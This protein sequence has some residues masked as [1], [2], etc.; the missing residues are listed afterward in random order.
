MQ[1][2]QNIPAPPVSGRLRDR[3]REV[4]MRVIMQEE[5]FI[6][7]LMPEAE[8]DRT[9]YPEAEFRRHF[10][11]VF[12]GEAEKN[13][14]PGYTPERLR[15][16]AHTYWATI[17]GGL[18]C[19]VDVVDETGEVVFTV[20]ALSDTSVLNTA[21]NPNTP[22]LKNLQEDVLQDIQG[23][24]DVANARLLNGLENKISTLVSA[25][26]G[27]RVKTLSRL[28]KMHAYYGLKTEDTTVAAPKSS[29]SFMGEMS[30]D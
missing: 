24:P 21:Q 9:R 15:G 2:R 14:P 19:E 12:S 4:G 10:L 29:G 18:S 25:G 28:A 23:R 17:A 5:A 22:G 1:P 30:F 3:V 16:E 27:D 8:T 13:L 20:P 11:P 26:T 6:R 7:T